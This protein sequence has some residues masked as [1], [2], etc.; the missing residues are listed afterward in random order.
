MHY[1]PNCPQCSSEYTYE[2]SGNFVCP[3]CGHEWKQEHDVQVLEEERIIKDANG[4]VLQDGDT[5]TVIRS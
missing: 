1:L 2:D 3:E 5:V 4:N